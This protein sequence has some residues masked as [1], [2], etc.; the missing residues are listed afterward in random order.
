MGSL[1]TFRD[2]ILFTDEEILTTESFE[3]AKEEI[4][5]SKGAYA[6][7]VVITSLTKLN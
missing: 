4:A 7:Y 6:K 5:E 3:K 1:L 2:G